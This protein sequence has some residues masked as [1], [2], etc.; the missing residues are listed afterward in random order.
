[1]HVFLLGWGVKLCTWD[2]MYLLQ[3][4]SFFIQMFL[5]LFFFQA[6]KAILALDAV[7]LCLGWKFFD[8]AAHLGGALFGMWVVNPPVSHPLFAPWHLF[9][10]WILQCLLITSKLKT[11]AR[12]VLGFMPNLFKIQLLAVP[13]GLKWL[14]DW[15]QYFIL[16]IWPLLLRT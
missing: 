11:T 6:L 12:S 3:S 1:M 9:V 10:F 4:R 5:W 15:F 16:L 13:L 14:G 2:I 7:G 8:H